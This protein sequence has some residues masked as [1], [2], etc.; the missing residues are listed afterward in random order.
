M[1]RCCASASASLMSLHVLG[2]RN[3]AKSCQI[4]KQKRIGLV[5]LAF[6]DLEV[7]ISRAK[8]QSTDD[9]GIMRRVE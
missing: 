5:A 8:Q 2:I 1:I 6:P 7:T 3:L 4:R 9:D